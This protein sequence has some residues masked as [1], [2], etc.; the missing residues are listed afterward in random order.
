MH[1]ILIADDCNSW[2]ESGP[3]RDVTI[4]DNKFLDCAYIS[5]P[6]NYV[7]AIKPETQNFEKGKYVHS[8]INITGNQFQ[9]FDTPLLFARDIKGLNFSENHVIQ[10]KLPGFPAGNTL[11]FLLEHCDNVQIQHNSFDGRPLKRDIKVHYTER[12]NIIFKPGKQFHLIADD[13][14][15][16]DK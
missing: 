4:R 14:H 9:V 3:V 6:G 5:A 2:F 13:A 16:E 12:T 11:A 15:Q 10:K 1:A 8:N 7:I